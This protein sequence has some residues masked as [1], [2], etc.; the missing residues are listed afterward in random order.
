MWEGVC[1]AWRTP[2]AASTLLQVFLFAPS[3]SPWLA[4]KLQPGLRGL[5]FFY[6]GRFSRA[7]VPGWVVCLFHLPTYVHTLRLATNTF[8][9]LFTPVRTLLLYYLP[10]Y[11]FHDPP[12]LYIPHHQPA[13]LTPNTLHLH[14]AA[15][16]RKTKRPAVSWPQRYLVLRRKARWVLDA[17]SSQPKD[18]LL[19]LPTWSCWLRILQSVAAC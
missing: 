4:G 18:T 19:A 1:A 14:R 3:H 9:S 17:E 15:P 10:R 12:A 2:V 16:R 13:S 8:G 11:L 6:E 5:A 7:S